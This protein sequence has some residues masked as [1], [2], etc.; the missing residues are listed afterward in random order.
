MVT[1]M[2]NGFYDIKKLVIDL[3]NSQSQDSQIDLLEKLSDSA[4]SYRDKLINKKKSK[5]TTSYCGSLNIKTE[6]ISE[7]VFLYKS[8]MV[9]N[10]Y[11]GDYLERFSMIRT[12]DLKTSGALNIHNQFWRAH[13]VISGNIFASLPLALINKEEAS[14]LE[15]LGWDLIHVDVY[16]I[17]LDSQAKNTQVEIINTISKIFDNYLLVKERYGGIY[18]VLHYRI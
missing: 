15:K 18:M 6:K 3:E 2:G 14:S 9:K 16:E 4:I 12:S 7:E 1:R 13:E 10:Y 11:E 8:V 5:T 17:I